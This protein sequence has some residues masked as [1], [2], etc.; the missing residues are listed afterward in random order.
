MSDGDTT[1]FQ[2]RHTYE[3]LMPQ[4][5]FTDTLVEQMDGIAREFFAAT[6][7]ERLE[8]QGV[9]D[10]EIDPEQILCA[11]FQGAVGVLDTTADTEYKE[12][13]VELFTGNLLKDMVDVE[14]PDEAAITRVQAIRVFG[15][16]L[17]SARKVHRYVELTG[18]V[19]AMK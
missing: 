1:L 5:Y 11:A 3:R 4:T 18:A 6:C 17:A 14:F 10:I 12:T 7:D 9:Y 19:E 8:T 2:L 16:V 13:A 15:D